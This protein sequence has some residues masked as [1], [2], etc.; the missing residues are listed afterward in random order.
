MKDK[1]TMKTGSELKKECENEK[2][3]FNERRK[4]RKR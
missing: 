4:E 3:S 1:E 2:E